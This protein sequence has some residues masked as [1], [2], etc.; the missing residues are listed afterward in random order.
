[1]KPGASR[2]IAGAAVAIGMAAVLVAAVAIGVAGCGSDG[3]P[4]PSH[5]E[6]DRIEWEQVDPDPTGTGGPHAFTDWG[7]MIVGVGGTDVWRSEDGRTWSRHELPGAAE[8]GARVVIVRDGNLLALGS[9][10]S[11]PA[12][13]GST[14]AERWARSPDDPDFDPAAGYAWGAI[15]RVAAGHDRLVAVGTEWGERGQRP[16][17]W[18]S[19]DGR[20]WTRSATSLTGSGARDVIATNE[21]FVLAAADNAR[22]GEGTRAAFWFSADG[23]EWEPAPDHPS[24]ANGEPSG[25]AILDGTIVAVG[26]RITALALAP[27]VWTS[28]DARTW[29]PVEDAPALSWW[30]LPGPTPVPDE[31][32]IQGT[33]MS[34]VRHT[35]FGLLA[36]GTHW[37]LDPARPRADGSHH[38]GFRSAMWHSTDGRTWQLLPE[39]LIVADPVDEAT[40]SYGLV[41]I[42]ELHGRPVVVGTTEANGTTLWLGPPQPD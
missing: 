36:V 37:G 30:P 25:L 6:P 17:A 26:Y 34:G 1:M 39:P 29:T 24:F 41:T 20:E 11:R 9:D 10:G 40:L 12:V 31:M 21:G 18:W 27:V 5:V 33:R 13:W 19:G 7:E 14:D 3:K 8:G 42:G 2:P 4:S 22:Q 28:E 16:V 32:A 15:E 35:W 38:L 23:D